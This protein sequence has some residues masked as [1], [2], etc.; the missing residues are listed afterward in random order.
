MILRFLQHTI[1]VVIV[2][3]GEKGKMRQ[4]CNKN[5]ILF[6]KKLVWKGNTK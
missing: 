4:K 6:S 5:D 2:C 1:T 3:G